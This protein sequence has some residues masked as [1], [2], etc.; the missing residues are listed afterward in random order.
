MGSTGSRRLA[1]LASRYFTPERIC[2]REGSSAGARA[3]DECAGVQLSGH[4][5]KRDYSSLLGNAWLIDFR[6]S[7]SEDWNI[8]SNFIHPSEVDFRGQ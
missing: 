5:R 7:T 2:V 6:P 8:R 3:K 1:S 4:V